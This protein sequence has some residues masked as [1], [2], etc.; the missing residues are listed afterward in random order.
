MLDRLF[1]PTGLAQLLTC[2]SDCP[3][4]FRKELPP[5]THLC[6]CDQGLAEAPLC[7]PDVGH[8][9]GCCVSVQAGCWRCSFRYVSALRPVLPRTQNVFLLEFGLGWGTA[10]SPVLPLLW[11]HQ[12]K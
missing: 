3:L 11:R 2:S 6:L 10:F 5:S 9:C 4:L 7:S 8:K 12:G 1:K